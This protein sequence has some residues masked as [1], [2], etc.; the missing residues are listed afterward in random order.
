M[1]EI[2]QTQVN[3]IE[4]AIFESLKDAVHKKAEQE[5]EL[6][7][8][9]FIEQLERDKDEFI[10]RLAITLMRQVQVMDQTHQV[11]ITVR[12]EDLDKTWGR[13]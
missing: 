2:T 13:N 1:T 3:S 5:Y 7:K 12:R 4:T 8:Q 10:S 6:A 11:V 9:R